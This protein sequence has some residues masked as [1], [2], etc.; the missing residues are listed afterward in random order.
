MASEYRILIDDAKLKEFI[1][2]VKTGDMRK[3][4][5]GADPVSSFLLG[6]LFRALTA[7]TAELPFFKL[8]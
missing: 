1:T 2:A 5:P 7:I 3:V 6:G 8:F 4:D